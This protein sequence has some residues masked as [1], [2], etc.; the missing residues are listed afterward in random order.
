MESSPFLGE[1]PAKALLDEA[2]QSNAFASR[3]LAGFA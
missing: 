1:N 3:K 2:A